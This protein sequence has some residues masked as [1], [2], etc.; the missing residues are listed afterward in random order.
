MESIDECWKYCE[1]NVSNCKAI[2][3]YIPTSK[4]QLF[5]NDSLPQ[6]FDPQFES[7]TTKKG[8]FQ[9]IINEIIKNL[10][11]FLLFEEIPSLEILNETQFDESQYKFLLTDNSFS[12]WNICEN[13]LGCNSISFYI[14]DLE[15]LYKFDANCFLYTNKAPEALKNINFVSKIRK[16]ESNFKSV[17]F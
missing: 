5:K 14:G 17:N 15:D 7:F 4:C 16:A 13:E 3:F 1:E 10:N 8:L 6:I 9:A 11:L 12:C 2:S